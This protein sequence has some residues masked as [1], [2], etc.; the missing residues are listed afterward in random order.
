MAHLNILIGIVGFVL[1]VVLTHLAHKD[2][3][4][5]LDRTL[6][7]VR[8]EYAER[9]I[10]ADDCIEDLEKTIKELT[11]QLINKNGGCELQ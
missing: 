9:L 6:N 3:I 11:L 2:T 5:S 7:R 8:A 10:S 1:G 4:K